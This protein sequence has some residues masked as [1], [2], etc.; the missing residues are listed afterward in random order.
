MRKQRRYCKFCSDKVDYIDFKDVQ[1]LSAVVPEG[2]KIPPSRISGVGSTHQRKLSR[3]IKRAR[4]VA[5][6]PYIPD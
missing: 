5:L 2:S 4:Q 1:I 6:L 3:A